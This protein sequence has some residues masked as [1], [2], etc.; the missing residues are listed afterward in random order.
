MFRPPGEHFKPGLNMARW[1][2]RHCSGFWQRHAI[3]DPGVLGTGS[4]TLG[5]FSFRNHSCRSSVA[6]GKFLWREIV[7]KR[8][9]A[10]AVCIS[11][12]LAECVCATVFQ[13]FVSGNTGTAETAAGG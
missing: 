7:K 3:F 12:T 8:L 5:E 13:G 9:I 1:Q 4:L 6:G 11:T 10:N 2:T